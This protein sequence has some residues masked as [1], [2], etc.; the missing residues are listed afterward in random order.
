MTG[1]SGALDAGA[2]TGLSEASHARPPGS[3][4]ASALAA[5]HI[6]D[7]AY[8]V[9]TTV[10]AATVGGRVAGGYGVPNAVVRAAL[11]HS[12]ARVGTGPCAP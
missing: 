11:R 2:A 1:G 4:L 7:R 8:T 12:N 3:R 9:V 5:S 6:G 10:F